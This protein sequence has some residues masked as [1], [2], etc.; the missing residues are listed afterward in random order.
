[1]KKRI[2]ND[3]AKAGGMQ[4]VVQKL[5]ETGR[6]TDRQTGRRTNRQTER[7]RDPRTI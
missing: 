2:N 3:A 5:T 1:M 7:Q 4:H 6:Q